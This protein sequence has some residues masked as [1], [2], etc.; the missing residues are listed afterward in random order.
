MPTVAGATN[1]QHPWPYQVQ[2]VE[3]VAPAGRAQP[4]APPGA[5]ADGP[6]ARGYAAFRGNCLACHAMNGQGGAVG[7][8]LNVP[9]NVT[10]YWR[11][12]P[13]RQLL[14]DPLSVR[15]G[16]KMPGFAHLGDATLDDVVAYLAYMK[17]HKVPPP[18]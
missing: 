14:A 2:R 1:A 8:D 7:P 3:L 17:N 9:L 13:L 6:V 5:P 18:R 15:A 4:M 16:A 10:E 11:P 12:A